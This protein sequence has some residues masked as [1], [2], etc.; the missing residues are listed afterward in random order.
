MSADRLQTTPAAIH[1]AISE[2]IPY[3]YRA[4]VN[5]LFAQL[6]SNAPAILD[7]AITRGHEIASQL[8]AIGES[9]TTPGLY[10]DAEPSACSKVATFLYAAMDDARQ[11]VPSP[12]PVG[13]VNDAASA[14][15]T[16]RQNDANAWQKTVAQPA[17]RQADS[18][19]PTQIGD[20]D[21]EWRKMQERDANAWKGV[22]R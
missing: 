4:E 9:Q 3:R 13:T 22:Q 20:T 18:G 5:V 21:T 7:S 15:E 16:M 1:D 6:K 17:L 12:Y 8:K 11:R 2:H 14:Y 19:Q 10:T